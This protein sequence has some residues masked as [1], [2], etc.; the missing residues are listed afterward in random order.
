MAINS[1]DSKEIA[2]YYIG[3]ASKDKTKSEI[4]KNISIAKSILDLGYKKEHIMMA[5]DIYIEKMYSLG[6]IKCVIADVVK[7]IVEAE[8]QEEIRQA[9][10]QQSNEKIIHQEVIVDYDNR[11]KQKLERGNNIGRIGKVNPFDNIK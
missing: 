6:F 9:K 8:K 2:L 11:N 7:A 4:I 1:T 5:I 10:E 3:K